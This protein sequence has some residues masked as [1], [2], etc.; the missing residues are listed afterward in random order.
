MFKP[1]FGSA[2]Q[3]KVFPR[4]SC[5]N[6]LCKYDTETQ[7]STIDRAKR[8]DLRSRFLLIRSLFLLFLGGKRKGGKNSQN[9]D[10]NS[11]LSA[12]LFTI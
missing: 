1:S 7:L 4:N 2:T 11:C 6:K 9:R 10:F 5:S 3:L 12:R 8:H